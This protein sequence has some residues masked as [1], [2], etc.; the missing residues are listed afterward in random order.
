MTK[1]VIPESTEVARL[2][3]LVAECADY[4]KEGETPRQR[5]DR[6]HADVL[7]LMEMLAKDRKER[8]DLRAEN[9]RLRHQIE[10]ATDPDFIWGALDNVH[11]CETT[12]DEYAAAV[13]RAIRAAL[14]GPAPGEGE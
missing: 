9:A 4:L 10:E 1:I 11:D 5:M 8:D 6:D 2:R 13:S 7:A 14:S 12:L 3:A